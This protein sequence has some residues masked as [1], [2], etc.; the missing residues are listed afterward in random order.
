MLSR[1]LSSAKLRAQVESVTI[2]DR[3]VAFHVQAN[4]VDQHV[5]VQLPVSDG[6]S[7]LNIHL[8]NDFGVSLTEKFPPLGEQARDCELSPGHG[9]K[10][11]MH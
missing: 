7:K 8:R 6:E 2:N 11:V 10:A 1:I 4:S 3:P 9:R 5:T